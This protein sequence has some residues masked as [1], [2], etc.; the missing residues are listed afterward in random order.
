MKPALVF[1]LAALLTACGGSLTAEGAKVKLMK[2]DPPPNCNEVGSVEGRGLGPDHVEKAKNV[3]RNHAAERGGNYV[4]MET[5]D[6]D[7]GYAT[8]TAYHCP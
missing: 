7:N 3:M 6:T 1:S 4:R 5:L 2:S 8:G